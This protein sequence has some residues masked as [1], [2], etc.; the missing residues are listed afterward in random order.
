MDSD[1][2]NSTLPLRGLGITLHQNFGGTSSLVVSCIVLYGSALPCVEHRN[3]GNEIKHRLPNTD[4][5]FT[6]NYKVRLTIS[7]ASFPLSS[8]HAIRMW[9]RVLY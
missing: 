3:T 6:C 1:S 9:C 7:H 8:Q 5:R 4:L 2:V